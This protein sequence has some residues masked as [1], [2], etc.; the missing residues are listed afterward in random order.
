M[1]TYTIKLSEKEFE[2]LHQLAR[3]KVDCIEDS[4]L[5]RFYSV[6]EIMESR[7]LYKKLSL[8]KPDEMKGT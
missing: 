4:Q 6:P 2:V 1:K 5:Q 3:A 7:E 8:T